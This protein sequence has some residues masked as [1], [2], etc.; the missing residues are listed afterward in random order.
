MR[1]CRHLTL[2]A[3]NRHSHNRMRVCNQYSY[4]RLL[5]IVHSEM[6]DCAYQ[7]ANPAAGT[8]LRD[9]HQ[10]SRHQ[11]IFQK[12][13]C[14]Y[15][16]WMVRLSTRAKGGVQ[17]GGKNLT[18]EAAVFTVQS[19]PSS[20][21]SE[22]GMES[23]SPLPSRERDL[24]RK[25]FEG[26]VLCIRVESTETTGRLAE[27]SRGLTGVGQAI[28]LGPY[29]DDGQAQSYQGLIWEMLAHCCIISSST[30]GERK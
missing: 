13:S 3:Y 16:T 11:I 20:G 28:L 29:S 4:C 18:A 17:F 22:L 9:Y 15:Y 21:G 6:F 26:R 27:S 8:L 1:T 12:D 24:Y 5:G 19:S 25:G 2:A 30:K 7:F 14:N 23:C 10:L